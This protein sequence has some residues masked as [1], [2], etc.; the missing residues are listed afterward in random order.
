MGNFGAIAGG[1]DSAQGSLHAV[2]GANGASAAHLD[3]G[4][5]GQFDVGF[6]AGRDHHQVRWKIVHAIGFDAADFHAA[7]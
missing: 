6:E 1:E 2:V 5:G 7:A 3:S 4:L